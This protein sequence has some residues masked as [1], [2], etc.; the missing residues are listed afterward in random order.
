MQED[1]DFVAQQE[2]VEAIENAAHLIVHEESFAFGGRG[3]GGCKTCS[4]RK[5]LRFRE[6]DSTLGTC[7]CSSSCIISL[8]ILNLILPCTGYP[9]EGPTGMIHIYTQSTRSSRSQPPPNSR[10]PW[11][12]SQPLSIPRPP[13]MITASSSL[14]PP[15]LWSQPRPRSLQPPRPQLSPPPNSRPPTVTDKMNLDFKTRFS[16]EDLRPIA[17]EIIRLG[18]SSL[19]YRRA[20]KSSHYNYVMVK[21]KWVWLGRDQRIY[22]RLQRLVKKLREKIKLKNVSHSLQQTASLHQ[23]IAKQRAVLSEL[24]PL[25]KTFQEA[26]TNYGKV[27]KERERLS[28]RYINQTCCYLLLMHVCNHPYIGM[29]L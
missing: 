22:W 17:E 13:T 12:L 29:R 1:K 24:Q 27:M 23:T 3:C 5:K 7:H 19:T 9:G 20:C 25:R 18:K 6:F 10:P 16:D 21:N 14:R 4:R 28:A 2:P 15:R 11:L 8:K 26:Q